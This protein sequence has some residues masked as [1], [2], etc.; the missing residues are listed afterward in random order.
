M[1]VLA[2]FG[3]DL[4][5]GG[6]GDKPTEPQPSE[7]QQQ[8]AGTPAKAVATPPAVAPTA[9]SPKAESPKTAPPKAAPPKAAPP[10]TTPP[11]E[12]A[13]SQVVV[14]GPNGRGLDI[15]PTIQRIERGE[16]HSHRNDGSVFQNRERRLPQKRRGY[17]R[18]YVHPTPGRRGPGAQRLVIGQDG[19][20]WYTPDHYKS[21]QRAKYKFEGRR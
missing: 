3:I 21:F 2:Y 13:I 8:Q 11:K 9:G 6:S 1:L 4:A 12:P 5:N 15:Y 16:R 18:E 14:R 17:Y 7:V 10:K 19:D 20:V